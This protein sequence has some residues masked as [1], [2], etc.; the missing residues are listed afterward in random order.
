[1]FLK[2]VRDTINRRIDELED[3]AMS[4]HRE[5]TAYAKINLNLM[6][7]KFLFAIFN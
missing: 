5:A 6:F 4:T 7:Q 1:M 2:M 3:L